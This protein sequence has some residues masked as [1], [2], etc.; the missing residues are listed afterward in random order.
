[1]RSFFVQIFL[2][3]WV[4]GILTFVLTAVIFPNPAHPSPDTLQVAL[5]SSVAQLAR[6]EI[7]RGPSAC[8]DRLAPEFFVLDNQAH[9][10]CGQIPPP[11]MLKLVAQVRS[12][13]RQEFSIVGSEAFLAQ[14][15]TIDEV[16]YVAALRT[17]HPAHTW[18]PHLPPWSL[19]VSVIVTFV[20]AYLLTKP[21]RA[22]RLAFRKFAAGDMSVRLP[23]SRNALRDWGGA[24]IRTLMIDFNE[25]ADRIQA[26]LQAHKH[27]CATCRTNCGRRSPD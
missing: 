7:H 2:S 14:P 16:T 5:R 12:A 19:P 26:L 21:V 8:K 24:D 9:E 1:V 4:S 18:F 17:P 22:L 6:S 11:Q 3:F 27:Y 10:T 15:V 13:N 23:V 25:M 20:V